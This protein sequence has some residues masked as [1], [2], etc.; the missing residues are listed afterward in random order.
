M[1]LSRTKLLLAAVALAI[2][3]TAS[4]KA[5]DDPVLWASNTEAGQSPE[6]EACKEAN[7]HRPGR[8]AIDF[9]CGKLRFHNASF[10][11]F[12]L[13]TIAV[14]LVIIAGRYLVRRNRP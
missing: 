1:R 3:G 8:Y 4:A 5:A 13:L 6:T 9:A 10:N 11:T 2:A 12:Q 14:L 7:Y